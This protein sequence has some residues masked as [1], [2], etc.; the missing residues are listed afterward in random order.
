VKILV[1]G[2]GAI[3]GYFGGRL[4]ESAVDVT[5]LVRPK[6]REQI[7]ANGLVIESPLGN[8]RI[9]ANTVVAEDLKPGYDIV[10][11]TCKA[12]DLDAAMEAIAPAV[13]GHCAIVPML[14][15]LAH[16][17]RLDV[18]FGRDR[19]MGGTCHINVTLAPD[20]TVKH[21]EPLNRIFFGEWDGSR[22]PR[23]LALEAAFART[24]IGWRHS[25]DILQEMWSKVV[26]LA[27]LAATTSLFRG[28]IA[29]ILAAQGG[30]EWVA[31]C[32]DA[33][34]AIA[35][36]EGHTPPA[37]AIEAARARLLTPG[38]QASSMMRDMEA[39]KPVEADHIIGHMLGL[40]R[41]HGIDD[42]PLSLAYTHV[43]AYEARRAA[44]RL[45]H[46]WTKP[47]TT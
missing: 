21:M 16:L 40:A 4:A 11:L 42:L 18:R 47:T 28:N 38:P 35:A 7:A 29:E 13:A 37:A 22:S 31:R 17:E 30:K 27:A 10:L 45:G 14:N 23:A 20:G 44:G 19:V 32:F 9:A 2:A 8:A 5:F 1:L 41:K 36:A 12:Y 15:G 3:G 39:G 26:F 25:E 43:K 6:R 33:N 46:P 24:S 34:L